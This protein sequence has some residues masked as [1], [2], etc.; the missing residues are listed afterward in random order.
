MFR[1]LIQCLRAFG[2]SGLIVY[3]KLKLGLTQSIGL[4]EIK[5][6]IAMRP[7]NTDRITFKEIFIKREYD[8]NFSTITDTGVIIDAGA[9]I[10]FTS[11]F[12]ANQYPNSKIFSIEPDHENFEYVLRNTSSYKNIIPI[13]KALWN[14]KET[15]SL[16]DPGLGKRGM[17]V[18]KHEGATALDAISVTDLMNEFN[19]SQIDILK[20]DIEGSEKEVFTDNY[21]FWLPRTK[22]LVIE[23]HDRMKKG[24]SASVFHALSNYDFSLS[25]KGENLVF[26]NNLPITH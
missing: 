9:N 4:P 7:G 26:I 5:F 13:K 25:I 10:G 15:I 14:K 2:I 24:C 16:S 22:C 3:V 23:L 21:D 8:L 20:M 17:M 12:L 6:P 19:I 11:V 18:D 1:F